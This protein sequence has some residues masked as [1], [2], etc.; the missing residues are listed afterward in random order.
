MWRNNYENV[1]KK[2]EMTIIIFK[3]WKFD[4]KNWKFSNFEN[5]HK[6]FV[7]F[8]KNF[9]NFL[10]LKMCPKNWKIDQNILKIFKFGKCVQ[11]ILLILKMCP[12][13]LKTW[14]KYL[15]NMPKIFEK[16]ENV[17]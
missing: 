16:F 12:N 11:N 7:K 13:I 3:F 1:H 5:V 4:E 15:A 10:M 9:E 2:L 8:D 6:I 14:Q 17:H